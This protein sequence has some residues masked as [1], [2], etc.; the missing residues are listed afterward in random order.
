MLGHI[1]PGYF[2]IGEVRQGYTIL[3][4]L[5]YFKCVLARLVQ[6]RSG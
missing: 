2:M 6:V 5:D 4:M 3:E 1:M